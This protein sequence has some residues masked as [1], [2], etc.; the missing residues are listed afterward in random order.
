[1]IEMSKEEFNL[2]FIKTLDELLEK[3][4]DNPEIELNKFY[5]MAYVMEN[6]AFFSPVIFDLVYKTK[7]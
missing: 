3:M 4:A 5:H 7:T 2:A 6:L 1:M